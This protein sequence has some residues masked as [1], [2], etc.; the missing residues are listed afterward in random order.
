MKQKG[1]GMDMEVLKKHSYKE[2]RVN[3]LH[4]DL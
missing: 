4:K 2:N 3:Q 1:M